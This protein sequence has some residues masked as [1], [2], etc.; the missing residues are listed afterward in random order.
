MRVLR[1]PLHPPHRTTPFSLLIQFLVPRGQSC[2]HIGW[3]GKP[4]HTMCEYTGRIHWAPWMISHSILTTKKGERMQRIPYKGPCPI[5]SAFRIGEGKLSV[6]Y[7]M[8]YL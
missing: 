5:A 3:T 7:R 1:P 8:K 2:A 4:I 6:Q